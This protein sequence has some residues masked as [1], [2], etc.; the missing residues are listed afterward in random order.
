METDWEAPLCLWQSVPLYEKVAHFRQVFAA[1]ERKEPRDKDLCSI[2][3]VTFVIFCGKSLF[4]CGG[5]L[6]EILG[7]NPSVAAGRAAHFAPL[8][9]KSSQMLFNAQLTRH[10]DSFLSSLIK[11][12]QTKSN[13]IQ[14]FF[15][16]QN[17]TKNA[18]RPPQPN[19]AMPPEGRGWTPIRKNAVNR[20]KQSTQSFF[21][22]A[23][24]CFKNSSSASIG[25]HLWPIKVNKG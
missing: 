11:P 6:W 8:G 21:S 10:A 7:S 19:P 20:R 17:P 24:R 14:L 13:Q 25:V 22:V 16:T 3:F 9:G 23:V 4:G 18:A 2:F 15:M 1:K 12:N 5:P